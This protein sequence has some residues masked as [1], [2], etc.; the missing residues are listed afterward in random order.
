[1]LKFRTMIPDAWKSGVSS[2]AAGD[3]RITRV[4]RVLRRL[5]LDELPQLWNV[6]TGDMSLVG[7]RPLLMEFLERY[8]PEEM[9][10]HDV[11]PGITGWAQVHGRHD[12]LFSRRLQLDLWYV[13]HCSFWLDLKIFGMTI[14]RVFAMEGSRGVQEDSAVD[15]LGLHAGIPNSRRPREV[16]KL[17]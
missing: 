10:R 2:T 13:D 4:G 1:M 11:P 12:I 8:T 16:Q 9:R 15:D 3:P 14:A 5:S 17:G 6:L 7:P